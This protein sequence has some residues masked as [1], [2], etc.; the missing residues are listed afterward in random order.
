MSYFQAKFI[1]NPKFYL[2]PKSL[3]QQIPK[4]AKLNS[5]KK[6]IPSTGANDSGKKT[7][8]KKKKTKTRKKEIKEKN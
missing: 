5:A 3:F 6:V 4:N 1:L 2:D 7:K 8:K